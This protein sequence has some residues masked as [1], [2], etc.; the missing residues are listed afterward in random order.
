MRSSATNPPGNCPP[1]VIYTIGHSSSGIEDFLAVLEE[2]GIRVLADIRRFPGSRRHPWFSQAALRASLEAAGIE[3]RWFQDLGGFR[4][5]PSAGLRDA[6]LRHP[7]FRAYAEHMRSEAFRAA[8]REL[9]VL[10]EACPTA[11]MCAELL[12]WR[13]HRM[14]LSDYLTMHGWGVVHILGK[15]KTQ[16]HRLT[17]EARLEHGEL[18]YPPGEQSLFPGG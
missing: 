18:A 17:E 1:R 11:Y 5:A 9:T 4:G 14:L 6:G 13:C 12:Y 7:A 3:Y 15:D 8:V 2:H 10:A 16:P